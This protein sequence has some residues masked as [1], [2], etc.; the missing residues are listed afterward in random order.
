MPVAAGRDLLAAA[1]RGGFALPAFNVS[2]AGMALGVLDAAEDRRASVLLQLTPGNAGPMGGLEPAAAHLLELARRAEVPVGLHLDHGADLPALRRA[3]E[4]GFTSVMFDGSTL[5]YGENVRETRLARAVASAAGVALE[6]EL[7]HVGG[8]EP[9]VVTSE[10]ALTDPLR[11]ADFVEAT[12]VDALAVSVGT[13]HGRSGEVRI[14]LL[15]EI[16]RRTG[17]LPLVL[18]GGSGV[19]PGALAAALAAGVRKVNVSREIHGAF[20]G[21]LS[22]ALAGGGED[23]RPALEAARAA[24]AAVAG[25]RID[26]LGAGASAP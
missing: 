12:G 16:R 5:P 9:G 4:A 20:T 14:P 7:G 22:A 24:V 18:H 15:L 10:T 11:A 26:A 25:A 8:S 6:A 23:P 3:V 1:A 2:T 13:A 21:A 17:A 19:A